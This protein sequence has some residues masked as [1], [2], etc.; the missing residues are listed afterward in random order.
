MTFEVSFT[1][2]P[3]GQVTMPG[4]VEITHTQLN[5]NPSVGDE[6]Y[7][8]VHWNPGNDLYRL[9]NKLSH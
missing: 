3:V 1:V 5:T 8:L 7:I 2:I 4:P 6:I 9:T